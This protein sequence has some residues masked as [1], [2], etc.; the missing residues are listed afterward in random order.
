[1]NPVSP[2]MRPMP[3]WLTPPNGRRGFVPDWIRLWFTTVLPAVVWA[4]K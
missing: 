1:M 4:R 3:E 2:P